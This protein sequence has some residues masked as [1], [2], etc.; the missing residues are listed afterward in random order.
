MK[1]RITHK[2]WQRAALMAVL[3]IVLQSCFV[4]KD[5]ERPEFE[6][7]ENLYR[8]DNLPA[9][10]TSMADVSWK[11][12]FT[13]THLAGYI[14][15]G[16]QNNIDVRVA[17]QQ[18][19]AAQA[20]LKQGKSGYLPTLS[21]S[22]TWTHQELSSNSQFG[23]L[24][25]S[26]DQYAISADL[27]WEADI[28]GKIRSNKRAYEATYLQSVAAHQAVKTA[29]IAQI[30]TTYYQL[31]A[32]DEQLRITEETVENRK[33]SV[34]TIQALKEAGQQNQVAVDQNAAQLYSAQALVIDLKN[35]IYQLENTLA[36]L[37]AETPQHYER[38]KLAD[39]KVQSDLKVG[40]PT[41]LLR[42]RP[43]VIAAEYGLINSFELTNVARSS[44]YPSL[45]LTAT[46]G[47]QA[48]AFEDLFD[49]RSLFATLVGGITQP[50][51]N[52]RQLKTQHEV[53]K[54]QQEQALL[55]F[56]LTLLTAGKEVS[57]AL[58]NYNAQ[59]EKIQYLDLQV[60]ALSNAENNSEE[61]LNNGLAN[62]LDLLTARE[63]RLNAELNLID[64]EL[65]QLLSVVNLYQALGGGW[66]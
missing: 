21:G 48:L 28:W 51:F 25:S 63:S 6:E 14:E 60:E 58:Y 33:R 16:L 34:E 42:N 11:E 15:K 17:I 61:L 31:V 23:S 29:L 2:L 1:K 47:L 8:T 57:E 49:S 46:G 62:Y 10:S 56:K 38:G 20:Y 64:T 37:L 32:Y 39:Q 45:T 44:F 24:F 5:Y 55:N 35:T 65:A 54:A 53:A 40:V 36:I 4:A 18:M 13:D 50:I 52:R 22:A 43:D 59:T 27:S 3:A 41:L 19:V 66:K 30:V 26:L 12:L 7:T 9:D